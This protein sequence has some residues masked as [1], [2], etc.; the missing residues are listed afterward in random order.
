[1][2]GAWLPIGSACATRAGR[3]LPRPRARDLGDPGDSV[4]T[5]IIDL[6]GRSRTG[7]EAGGSTTSERRCG[8]S[9][10]DAALE[11]MRAGSHAK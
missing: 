9:G 3:R 6:V 2:T 8:C 7:R 5:A 11:S 1:M 4:T 10:A